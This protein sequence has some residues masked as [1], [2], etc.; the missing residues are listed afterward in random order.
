MIRACI[1]DSPAVRALTVWVGAGAAL[2]VL[3]AGLLS[4]PGSSVAA[5]ILRVCQRG[6][7]Y[8][9]VQRAIDAAAAGDTISVG[10]GDY[11]GGIT[12]G[13]P[14]TVTGSGPGSTVIAGGGPVITVTAGPGVLP[15]A[16]PPVHP[17]PRRPRR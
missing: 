11:A 3:A 14:L 17:P 6:C 7:A 8:T 15:P 13:K 2:G 4:A 10:P 5:T 1:Q 9:Q 16:D 12:I